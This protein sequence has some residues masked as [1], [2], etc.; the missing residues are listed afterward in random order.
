M[1]KVETA[2]VVIKGGEEMPIDELKAK[3]PSVELAY[4]FVKDSYDV[5]L[6]RIDALDGKIQTVISLALTVTLAIPVI[7]VGM[8]AII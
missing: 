7:T 4:P 3:Y 6:K 2:A 1:S 8:S 5:L